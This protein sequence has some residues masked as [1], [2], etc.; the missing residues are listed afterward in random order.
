MFAMW[1]LFKS[2]SL[3]ISRTVESFGQAKCEWTWL[4][5]CT[6]SE[7]VRLCFSTLESASTGEASGGESSL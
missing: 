1:L 5:V 2:P 3:A 4:R 6:N 7:L